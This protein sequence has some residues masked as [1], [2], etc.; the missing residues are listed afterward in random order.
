MFDKELLNTNLERLLD[1]VHPTQQRL[2]TWDEMTLTYGDT[3]YPLR[4][5]AILA[6]IPP[7][8]KTVI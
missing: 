3:I 8:W 1:I 6:A 5:C 4:Y 2:L 7:V